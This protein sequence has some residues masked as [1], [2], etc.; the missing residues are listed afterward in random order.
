MIL[1]AM[2]ASGM[3]EPAP[4]ASSRWLRP[5][6]VAK[7][8]QKQPSDH[9]QHKR[10]HHLNGVERFRRRIDEWRESEKQSGQK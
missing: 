4:V 3:P 9:E 2:M 1:A 7:G 5:K 10:E 6:Q 8:A